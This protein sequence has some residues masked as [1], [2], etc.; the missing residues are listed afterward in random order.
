MSQ[1]SFKP[2]DISFASL[3][4]MFIHELRRGVELPIEALVKSF[5]HL[6]EQ[7][8]D[9]LPVLALLENSVGRKTEIPQIQPP[10]LIG[11]CQLLRVIGKG[12][13]G[14]VYE[15]E[16]MD[17]GRTVAVKIIPLSGNTSALERFEVEAKAMGRVDHPH[18]TPVY[19]YG[20]DQNFAYIVMK[21]IQGGSLYDL[22]QNN[23]NYRL[24]YWMNEIRKDWNQL[25]YLGASIASGLQHAHDRGLIHRDI[26][27]A[28][29]LLDQD[30][31]GWITDFGLAKLFDQ[32]RHLSRTGDAIGTP[33]YMA[34]EQ[35]RGIS[36]P[37]SD[38][39]SLG[40]TLYEI[41][42]GNQV[43]DKSPK[44]ILAPE[45]TE[46]TIPHLQE[47]CPSIPKNLAEVIMK[48][49]EFD[50][51]N[52]FQ[53]ANE[54]EIV[55]RRFIAGKTKC[56]RRKRKRLPDREFHLRSRR[57]LVF[58]HSSCLSLC[59]TTGVIWGMN[60]PR[61]G[62]DSQERA[63][64]PIMRST[65]NLID[66]L[67]D[68]SSEDMLEIVTDYLL[69]SIE[70]TSDKLHYTPEAKS[71]LRRQVEIFSAQIKQEGGINK[72][73][74]DRFLQ[75]YR[76]TSLP[77]ATRVMRASLIVEQS[78]LNEQEKQS[79]IVVLRHLAA[80]VANDHIT[81]QESEAFLSA[82][83]G[84]SYSALS[85]LEQYR[86]P[87]NTLRKWVLQV[88]DRLSQLPASAFNPSRALEKALGT[89]I[90]NSPLRDRP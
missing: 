21:Y 44:S 29:I 42:A 12:A 53:T 64:R 2:S 51:Q 28:N 27:P 6:E 74:L 66:H 41:V 57:Q 62:A 60:R 15:A 75:K 18:I 69:Q 24:K 16:Q 79:A 9:E 25:A 83:V 32:H 70:E 65:V 71:Q 49:C 80:A 26:K 90:E 4:E 17:I 34:P 52:R 5:P 72:E 67:A 77:A 78:T 54:L 88:N 19:S 20:H 81:E 61:S 73:T 58:L 43:W 56:D 14:T 82:L 47:T 46:L 8:R 48:C 35:L 86:V 31:K 68:S 3:A 38:V 63:N 33:R 85:N 37:R 89:M 22:Q 7:I 23:T 10:T 13:M 84:R 50:P 39:F 87:D 30:G 36:D 1:S 45:K 76:E 59:I 11:G 40:V 55:L